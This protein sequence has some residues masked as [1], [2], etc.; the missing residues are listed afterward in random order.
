[1]QRAVKF[2]SRRQY[3]LICSGCRYGSGVH[4]CDGRNLS[5]LQFG[6]FP[7]GEV[8]CGVADGKC[9]VGRRIT[10]TKAGTAESGLE[11][12]A[13]FQNRSRTAIFNQFHIDGHGG[14]IYAQRKASCTDGSPPQNIRRRADVLKTACTARNN[15]LVHMEFPIY[16]FVLQ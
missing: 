15:P 6:T 13:C 4:Q 16:D 3:A 12:R 8:P 11:H 14:R 2:R 5:A 9:I 1:M 7:V 10:C